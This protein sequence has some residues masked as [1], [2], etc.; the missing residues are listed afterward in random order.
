MQ[1]VGKSMILNLIAQN[2]PTNDLCKQI[3]NSHEV[4]PADSTNDS[5]DITSVE[6]KI[7][8]LNIVET[9]ETQDVRNIF[10][11][12][13]QDIEYIERGVHCTKGNI[14]QI[15]INPYSTQYYKTC[16]KFV[17]SFNLW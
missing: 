13:M 12:K 10:K 9:Q 11:F 17:N 1:G 8:N 14:K 6:N 5:N 2:A 7:E 4:P 16:Y 15:N 3:L